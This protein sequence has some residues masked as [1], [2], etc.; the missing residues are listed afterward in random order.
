MDNYPGLPGVSGNELADAMLGQVMD[1][2]GEIEMED[3][4]SLRQSETGFIVST[5]RKEYEG[6]AVILAT[7]ARPRPLGL[8]REMELTG[9]G[10]SYCALCDG[11]F[12]K[13]EDVAV[14]GGGNSA[15]QAAVV[16]ADICNSVT[17]IQEFDH[18]TCDQKD[19]EAMASRKNIR[20]MRSAKV[21]ALLGGNKLS[22][23]TVRDQNTGKEAELPVTGAFVTI[24]RVPDTEPFAGLV[25]CDERG[26]FL[27]D[28]GC[29][30]SVQG[31]WVAGDCRQKAV[32]QLTTAAADGAIA[33]VNACRYLG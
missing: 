3:I 5:G 11:A 22:G 24:G 26:F 13:N 9:R 4:R 28:E 29:A 16:L 23:L 1:L 19:Y 25:R 2:G 7:G 12:H 20:E 30:T 6:R 10:I 15:V 14:V 32:R 33:A 27:T 17:V 18:F 8:D 21:T 31:I